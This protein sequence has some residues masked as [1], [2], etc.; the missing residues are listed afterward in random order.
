M[1]THYQFFSSILKE[2]LNIPNRWYYTNNT[3]P[4]SSL[5]IYYDEYIEKFYNKVNQKK[6]EVIY[7]AKSN[8]AEFKNISFSDLLKNNCF[9]VKKHNEMLESNKNQ[10]M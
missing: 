10:E 9:S 1:I 6:I 8:S 3:F 4:A 2:N 7:L 5:N